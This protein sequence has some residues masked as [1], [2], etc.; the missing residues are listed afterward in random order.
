MDRVYK[1]LQ[2]EE[3]QLGAQVRDVVLRLCLVSMA[4]D[5]TSSLT[6]DQ[7]R[8]VLALKDRT[9]PFTTGERERLKAPIIRW[10]K[11]RMPRSLETIEKQFDV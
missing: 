9:T 8:W 3:A 6:D 1:E 11:E 5:P 7:R 2:R 4:L 10:V